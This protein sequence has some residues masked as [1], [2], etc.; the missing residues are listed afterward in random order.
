MK[1]LFILCAFLLQ[2][3]SP[4]HSQ[5]ATTATIEPNLKYGK[6]SKEELSLT[7]YAPDT[8]ATAIYLF[9]QG[10]SDFVYHDG[11]QLTTEHWVRIKILKP[12]GVSYA[13]VSVPYYSPTDR[14][15][16]Q[17]R[18]S[19]IEGCSYNMENGK[20][21]KTSMKRESISFERINNLYK[22]LKFSLPA[23]KEGTVIEYHYK[24]YS[25][26]FSH[27]DNWM[28][29]EELPMLYN[30]YKITIPHVFIY[31]I[32]LRGKDYIQVK[33]RDSSIHATERE[34]G[35]AGVSKDFIVSAQ[36]TTFTSRNLPAIRQDEPY[37]WCPED[38]K[39]QVSFD[40][41]G[42]QF[43][44]NEYKPYSQKWEDVDNQ[45]LKP[46]NTQFGKYLSF[47]NPFRP[48]TKQAYNSEMSFEEK[49]ICAFQILK[50]KMAWNGRYQLYS[51]ELEK[52]IPKGNGSNADLNFILISILKDF[53]LEAYP[54]VLSRRSSG[55]LP[56]NFP[57]LQKLNTF[58]VA[59]YDINKQKYVFLDGSMDV[60]ALN[61]LP[62]ELSVNKAR[63]LSP[64]EKEEKK[65]V[66]V[67]ALADNKSFMKIEARL[68]GNQVKGHRSTI[69]YGQ[70]AVEYQANEKH[71]QDSIVSNPESN[72]SLKNKLTV[73]NLK[74]KKQENDR[75][76]I[77]EEF[78]FV[79]QTDRTDDHLYINPMLFPHLKSNPFIQT[80]RVLPI[81]F[82]YPYK[83]TMLTT[84][85]L[86]EGY[87]VEETPQPQ[88]IRTQGD[89]LQCKY[90]IQRQGNTI[91]LNYIFYLKEP[92]FLTEQYKQ[93]QELWTKVIEKNNEILVLKKI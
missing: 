83:F 78:D 89:G 51:K 90:M 49:I 24:L 84:L 69:L 10:Q 61:I 80:E 11:F 75:A 54:V 47:T 15:E 81:E 21:I 14:D 65:W 27:I 33:Q 72:G 60:P 58:I 23:V 12:Q 56:Y 2:F 62:L 68:E 25:D 44:P 5:Q 46:E 34:G 28:M 26:Y 87:E 22:M 19:D 82:P 41:Q 42:T 31:N 63:I 52:V 50:K 9:H 66:N 8:T 88:V 79:L 7:S 91:S 53:G 20:C 74:V 76:L 37:C 55:M 17:E 93:L 64:K 77:E 35:S 16:G 6:P 38:Y 3:L 32:E 70:E 39:V 1:K 18:A 48:E 13:D 30:Q 57:S 92:I 4:V 73:T 45:L 43:T 29:Q 86:P 85:T 40:L 36:E 59:V 67:M 71:K